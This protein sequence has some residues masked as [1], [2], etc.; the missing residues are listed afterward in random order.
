MSYLA[1]FMISIVC[2]TALSLCVCSLYKGT[3]RRYIVSV[4]FTKVIII[5]TAFYCVFTPLNDTLVV[6]TMFHIGIY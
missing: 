1:L 3:G 5:F 4:V 2:V 6:D